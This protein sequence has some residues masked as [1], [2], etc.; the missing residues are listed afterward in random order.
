MTMSLKYG[1]LYE[2]NLAS[3]L[4]KVRCALCVFIICRILRSANPLQSQ[5]VRYNKLKSERFIV[6]KKSRF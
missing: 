5:S 3:V 1:F 2:T 6:T 4:G